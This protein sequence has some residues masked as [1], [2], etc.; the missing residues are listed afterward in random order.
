MTTPMA[1]TMAKDERD[2]MALAEAV[3]NGAS[4]ARAARAAGMSPYRADF[5]WARIVARLGAQ[6]Q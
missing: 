5:L 4:I 2:M 1:A 6:A 3:A